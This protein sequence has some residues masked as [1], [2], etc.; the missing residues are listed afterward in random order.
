MATTSI[1]TVV[2]R[3]RVGALQARIVLLTTLALIVDGFDIQAI[4]FA[5]PVLLKEWGLTKSELAPAMA[6]ALIGMTIGAPIGGAIG[7]RIGRRPAMIFSALFFGIATVATAWSSNLTA[8]TALRLISGLGFGALLPNAAAL[9]A[10]WMPSR[11]R[12]YAIGLMIVGVP[13]GGMV[14]AAISAR[15]IPELGWRSCFVAGGAIAI[16]LA[17]LLAIGLPESLRFLVR[18]PNGAAKVSALLNSAFGHGR[19]DGQTFEATEPA[20]S[21]GTGQVLRSPNLRVTYGLSLAFFCTLLSGYAFFSW[22]PAMLSSMGLPLGVAIKGS[23]YFNLWGFAGVIVSAALVSRLGSRVGLLLMGGGA[24][25]ITATTAYLISAGDASTTT[26]MVALSAAGAALTGLQAGL[27]ALA[28]NAYPTEC[29]STGVGMVAGVGR[30]G[31]IVS[32]FAGGALLS[33]AGGEAN[34]FLFVAAVLAVGTI[35]VLVVNRHTRPSRA[36]GQRW[37]AG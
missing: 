35:G 3:E 34:F 27:Y 30:A 23:F 33:F 37:N 11:Y 12:S 20:A 14:G 4:S 13:L 21:S 19:F 1:E 5:S 15:L 8:L 6:A 17:A 24:I 36:N 18:R 31:S 26:M 28:A 10:E 16:L 32:A 29:R 7:D 9:Q 25:L 2:E 22:I